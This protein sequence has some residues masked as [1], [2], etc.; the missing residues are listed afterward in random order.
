MGRK[1]T[2]VHVAHVVH[3]AAAVIVVVVHVAVVHHGVVHGR[4]GSLSRTRN[5]APAIRA[6]PLVLTVPVL[7]LLG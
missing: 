1:R 7:M 3:A 5:N 2:H 4:V 6:P